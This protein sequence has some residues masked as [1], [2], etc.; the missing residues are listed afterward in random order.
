MISIHTDVED[1]VVEH[2]LLFCFHRKNQF[3]RILS[4]CYVYK[5]I[6]TSVGI[7][8]LQDGIFW[9]TGVLL[10]TKNSKIN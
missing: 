2:N 5:G 8:Q 10:V 4:C 9:L 3:F 7:L 6:I 1:S